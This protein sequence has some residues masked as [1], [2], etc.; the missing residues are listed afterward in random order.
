MHSIF[1]GELIPGG[2]SQKGQVVS[3][4]HSREQG[5]RQSRS[6]R[7]SIRSGQAQ[8]YGVQKYLESSPKYSIVVQSEAR[9]KKRIAVLS[10]SIARNRPY[11]HTTCA[12][13]IE[14][15]VF[16]KT[17]EDLRCKVHQSP[18]LPR[19]V[20]TPNLQHRRQDPS[21]P[22]EKFHR[23]SKRTK[24]EV[25]GICR[26]LFEDTRRKHLEESQRGKYREKCR[27]NVDYRIPGIPHSTVQK[28]D[29]N[30]KRIVKRLRNSIRPAKSRRS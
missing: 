18:R 14:K 15:V 12:F 5:V 7:S 6:G 29:S 1:H 16:M 17:G 4:F 9:S 22:S 10:T 30:R 24:R 11:Q 3:V 25:Q 27:G 23:P 8:N 28:E 2:K 21:N 13:C 20:L 19:V 26:S